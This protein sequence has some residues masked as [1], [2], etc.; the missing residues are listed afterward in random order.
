VDDVPL[1]K[2]FQT[3]NGRVFQKVKKLR[4]RY[5][6]REISTGHIY[7]VPAIM[8]VQLVNGE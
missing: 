5:Q 1:D 7:F 6:C 4:S 3:R 2:A 8:E